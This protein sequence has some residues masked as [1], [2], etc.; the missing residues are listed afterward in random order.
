MRLLAGRL[1]GIGLFP[2][3]SPGWLKPRL[4]GA[5]LVSVMLHGVLIS[6]LTP[7]TRPGAAREPEPEPPI[8]M[9]HLWIPEPPLQPPLP[10]GPIAPTQNTTAPK[11]NLRRAVTQQEVNAAAAPPP[12]ATP[13]DAADSVSVP[14][15]SATPAGPSAERP[16]DLS[17]QAMGLAVSR[18]ATPSLA[19]AAREQL[20]SGPAPASARLGQH[21]ASGAVPDCLHNAQDGEGKSRP[22]AI[23]G[24]LALPF[25]AYAAMTGRCK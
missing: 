22:V 9:A 1:I 5:L 21:M 18:S 7:G 14:P 6:Q 20:G 11:H 25:V 15:P 23:G 24:L 8:L 3:P 17:P 10:Q 4:S 16:L 13:T 19:Q 2:W 12:A